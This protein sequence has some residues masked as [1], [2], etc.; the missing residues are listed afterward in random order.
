MVPWRSR[1]FVFCFFLSFGLLVMDAK[2]M[3]SDL[4]TYRPLPYND[5]LD[6]RSTDDITLV[7]LHATELPDLATA[8]TYGER[9]HYPNSGTGNSGHFYIDRDGSIE[10][11]VSMDRVAHH[12]K[13]HNQ[14]SIGI[15]LV[16]LGRYPNWYD[17]QHQRWQEP[18]TEAQLQALVQ[19]VQKLQ[20]DLSAL[21]TIAGHD[22]LDQR[23]VEASDDPSLTVSRKLDP[24]PD[25]PWQRMLSELGL[26]RF[27]AE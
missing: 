13:G 25:F 5:R 27:E 22:Q 17:S 1:A 23:R 16:S 26:E 2:T 7:V 9:I 24:G 18:I 4:S 21:T 6:P 12:V 10:Q 8:R 19:L 3:A 11:W 15:E 14:N 20:K